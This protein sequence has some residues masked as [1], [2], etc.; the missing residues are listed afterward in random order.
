MPTQ[1]REPAESR[2]GPPPLPT[3]PGVNWRPVPRIELGRREWRVR[4]MF[5]GGGVLGFGPRPELCAPGIDSGGGGVAAA[6]AHRQGCG[7]GGVAVWA[8]PLCCLWP[9][10]AAAAA[11]RRAPDTRAPRWVAAKRGGT[12]RTSRAV[13]GGGWCSTNGWPTEAVG[14]RLASALGRARWK[15]NIAANEIKFYSA[16]N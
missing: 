11:R 14:R 12:A 7:R 9:S 13:A 16:L 4:R 8:E 3:Q 2:R 10:R 15:P 6:G 5:R 1:V